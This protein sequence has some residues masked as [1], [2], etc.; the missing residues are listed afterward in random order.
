MADKKSKDKDV[1]VLSIDDVLKGSGIDYQ[2]IRKE[3]TE[4]VTRKDKDNRKEK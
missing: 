4:N 3:S 2:V 1:L